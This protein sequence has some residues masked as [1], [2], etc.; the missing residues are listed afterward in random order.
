MGSPAFENLLT[1]RTHNFIFK[2]I[3]NEVNV[4]KSIEVHLH[5]LTV[6]LVVRGMLKHKTEDI[7]ASIL[8]WHVHVY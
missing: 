6:M 5:C 1:H 3:E 7:L 4:S 2:K 8:R